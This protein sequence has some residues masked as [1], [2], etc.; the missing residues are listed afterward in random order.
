MNNV[1]FHIGEVVANNTTYDYS[2]EK[3]FEIR[4]ITYNDFY[5]REELRAIPYDSNVKKIPAIGEH[6]L[7]VCGLSQENTKDSIY[8]QWYYLSSFSI[9]SDPNDNKLLEYTKLHSDI[10]GSINL[11]SKQVS[12][13]Q[14]FSGDL[15]FEGR[16]GQSLR[17]SSTT[18]QTY[19][20]LPTWTGQIEGDPI[21]VLSN[22][23]K[24]D[25]SKYVVEN[26]NEDASSLYLTSTQKIPILLGDKNNR[27]PLSCYAPIESSYER[28]QFI[29]VAD[30]IILKAKSD[31]AVIDSPRG[32]VLNTTGEVKIGNDEANISLVHGDVLL[33]ILQKILN[34]LSQPIQCGSAQGTFINRTNLAAAQNELQNLLNSKYFITKDTY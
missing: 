18:K 30:R 10:T 11:T 31:I 24:F 23:R 13:L 17:F 27:N 32:I 4:V 14:P 12:W 25:Q 2:V 3:N 15:T 20:T 21:I 34:Q 26:V 19:S 33:N 29:G 5:N 9:N 16:F 1:Q 6:V 28:S 22:G 8:P 7:L